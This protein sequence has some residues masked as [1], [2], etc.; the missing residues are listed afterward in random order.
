MGRVFAILKR[1]GPVGLIALSLFLLV[2]GANVAG[3]A[4]F[5]AALGIIA[6]AHK[7]RYRSAQRAGVAV[8][9]LAAVLGLPA[10]LYNFS[11]ETCIG[12]ADDLSRGDVRS[13]SDPRLSAEDGA[14]VERTYQSVSGVWGASGLPSL[15][16]EAI[17]N[18]LVKAP[19]YV[20]A[21]VGAGPGPAGADGRAREALAAKLFERRSVCHA[22]GAGPFFAFNSARA[23]D[24]TQILSTART[25]LA[26]VTPALKA[27]FTPPPALADKGA[28]R[29]FASADF[30]R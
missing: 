1:I 17:A 28:S 23:R 11:T 10:A 27:N 24:E 30:T 12:V 19:G 18:I 8:F 29:T 5:A 2:Y 26:T 3:M 25:A 15:R 9:A 14:W 7:P 16:R 6:L 20:R 21:V 13:M 4:A 22:F